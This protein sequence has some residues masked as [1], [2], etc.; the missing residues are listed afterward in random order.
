MNARLLEIERPSFGPV[1]PPAALGADVYRGHL[2]ALRAAAAERGL[3]HVLVYGDRE[4]VGNILWATGFDPRFE[5]ALLVV[6]PND[7]P[8]VLAGNECLSYV[9]ASPLHVT[10]ELRRELYQPF[11]LPSQP[12]DSSRRL[13]DILRDEGVGS[14]SRVGIVGWKYL[15]TLEHDDPEHA[16]DVPTHLADTVRSLVGWDAVVNATDLLIHPRY[17]LRACAGADEIAMWEYANAEAS[18]ATWALVD[19]LPSA[20]REGWTDLDVVREARVGGLPL[21]CHLTFAVGGSPGLGGPTGRVIRRGDSLGFNLCHWGANIC[22]A[23]W[24]AEGPD[25]VAPEVRDYVEAYVGP[26]VS[27]IS[28]W[29]AMMVPGTRGGDVYDLIH[30]RLPDDVYGI[31]LNPG[32][33]IAYEEWMSSPIAAGSDDPL[34]SGMVLQIDIIPTHPV[35]FSTRMEE[36]IVIADESLQAELDARHPEVIGRCRARRAFMRDTLGF[37]VPDTVLP[38]S[39]VAGM[40][41]PWFLRPDLVV[42]LA[43]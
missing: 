7:P 16:V 26:Y 22:R 18:R 12:R 40:V 37:D 19:T 24:I 42:A 43:R 9:A 15:T 1:S 34:R 5:E 14:G 31:D 11:S 10:G 27:A 38:L 20:V 36:G 29:L 6:G 30:R 13:A 25:D 35:Y 3:T 8:L 21:G 17:G 33:L 39:D 32:H 4:H 41:T 2:A 23:G 28:E